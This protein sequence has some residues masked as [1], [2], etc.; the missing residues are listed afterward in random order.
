M[1]FAAEANATDLP[2]EGSKE[3]VDTVKR[4]SLNSVVVTANKTRINRNSVPLNISMIGREDIESS[5]SSSVL[6]VLSKL[7]PGLFVT[8]KGVTGFGVSE[9]AAGTI[10]IRG[11]GQG[12]KVLMLLDG[13]PQW[14]GIFGHSIPDLYTS[15]DVERV[16]VIKGPGSLLYGSNAMGGVINVITR[17]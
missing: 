1:A 12:N 13:Q 10:N 15:S 8:Q 9:G 5:G 16:E 2:K 17:E 7:V 11:V 6:P 14:A 3:A 4:G